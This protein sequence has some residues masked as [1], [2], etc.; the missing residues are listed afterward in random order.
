MA[1]IRL[2]GFK[3]FT[4]DKPILKIGLFSNSSLEKKMFSFPQSVN[5]VVKQCH[6]GTFNKNLDSETAVQIIKWIFSPFNPTGIQVNGHFQRWNRKQAHSET[7]PG[8]E[9]H[10]TMTMCLEGD[11][12]IND[13][14][15]KWG[16]LIYDTFM[17]L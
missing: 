17:I 6:Q 10:T 3:L 11:M 16:I 12:L 5:L 2:S 4:K 15:R 13:T 9:T 7:Q 14:G 1:T 8:E